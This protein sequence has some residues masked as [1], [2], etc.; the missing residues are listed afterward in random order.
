MQTSVFTTRLDT[1]VIGLIKQ[2]ASELNTTQREFVE[3]A[4]RSLALIQKRKK[5][6]ESFQQL[7]N[8]KDNLNL[9]DSGFE[10]L[11]SYY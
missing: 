9:A 11:L 1:S 8:D 2:S 3:Q 6:S 10:E 5:I 7:Q 4:V